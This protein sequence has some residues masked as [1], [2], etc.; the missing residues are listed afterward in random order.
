MI[1]KNLLPVYQKQMAYQ[2]FPSF[3][4]FISTGSL[5]EDAIKK[6]KIK[7]EDFNNGN[8]YSSRHPIC[9]D[10]LS[11]DEVVEVSHLTREG[12]H[13]KPSYLEEDNPLDALRRKEKG[14]ELMVDEVN[15]EDDA[16]KRMKE[17]N[18]NVSIWN[19]LMHSQPHR[20]AVLKHLNEASVDPSITPDQIVGLIHGAVTIPGD[21]DIMNISPIGKSVLH[22]DEE[23]GSR[24]DGFNVFCIQSGGWIEVFDEDSNE[25]PE[26][27][28]EIPKEGDEPLYQEKEEEPRTLEDRINNEQQEREGKSWTSS[29]SRANRN[30]AR[31]DFDLDFDVPMFRV[32]I[33]QEKL[34]LFLGYKH[35][36]RYQ[37]L[38]K[39]EKF[40]GTCDPMIHLCKFVNV[41]SPLDVPEEHLPTL[42]DRSLEGAA[43]SWYCSFERIG[44]ATWNEISQAFVNWAYN[45]SQTDPQKLVLVTT[46]QT[47][48]E[49]F[50]HFCSRCSVVRSKLRNPITDKEFMLIMLKNLNDF[51]YRQMVTMRYNILGHMEQHGFDIDTYKLLV[52]RPRVNPCAETSKRRSFTEINEPLSTV[53]RRLHRQGL[54]RT[55]GYVCAILPPEVNMERYCSYCS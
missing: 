12:R 9:L 28:I 4:A 26:D 36:P 10:D 33:R 51:Y 22:L 27:L 30:D 43:L 52:H 50:S 55:K 5:V 23:E 14:K 40:D 34:I 13:F 3:K 42:F 48:Q 54:I 35:E 32:P 17:V 39:L 53:Y 37:D 25:E 6:G 21:P 38:P 24:L 44:E 16:I 19:L 1:V 20:S 18:A 15:I 31:D 45:F 29:D 7:K 49:T 2:Y 47:N 46:L 41:L 8:S 11:D